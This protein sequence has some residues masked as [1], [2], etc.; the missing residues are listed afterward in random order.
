MPTAPSLPILQRAVERADWTVVL[1]ARRQGTP[2]EQLR[3]RA[4]L[5]ALGRALLLD[6]ADIV[7]Q[8]LVLGASTERIVLKNGTELSPLGIAM[9]QENPE[10][11]HLLLDAG[12]DPNEPDPADALAT[13]PLI[14]A[15]VRG[16][17]QAVGQLL[18]CGANP[19]ARDANGQTAWV[20]LVS[21][22]DQPDVEGA[23]LLKALASLLQAGAQPS[24]GSLARIDAFARRHPDGTVREAGAALVEGSK[25]AHAFRESLHLSQALEPRSTSGSEH[26]L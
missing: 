18:R 24:E 12:V 21:G 10:L 5:T 16:W 22:L 11:V 15:A 20:H 13:P 25:K 9:T 2:W 26:R 3:T 6:S 8:M 1:E 23:P 17:T 4:G 19:N 14:K 7:E